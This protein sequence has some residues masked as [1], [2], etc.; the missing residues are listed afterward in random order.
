VV[1]V[2][3][4]IERLAALIG[5]LPLIGHRTDEEGVRMMPVVRYPFL[6]FYAVSDRPTRSSSSTFGM[7]HDCGHFA[8][9]HPG[10]TS[11]SAK[12]A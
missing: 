5:E 2:V 3:D 11:F 12:S 9:A 6:I 10:Y 4:R 1:A 7:L 8:D